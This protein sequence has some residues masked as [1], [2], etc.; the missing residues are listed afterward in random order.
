MKTILQKI[1]AL[2]LSVLLVCT[3]LP[4]RADA[5]YEIPGSCQA[6]TDTNIAGTVKTMDYSYDHNTYFSLRD[7]AMLLKDTDKSFSD[8]KSVV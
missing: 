2:I 6:Q 3:M 7:I 4:I 8:R 5:S 1:S